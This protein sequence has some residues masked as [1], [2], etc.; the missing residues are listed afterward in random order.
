M[1][2]NR[3]SCASGGLSNISTG[4]ESVCIDTYRVLDSC[5]DKDCYEN[6]RVYLTDFGQEILN[7]TTNIRTKRADILRT[8][9]NVS[10]VQFNRGFYQI[11]IRYYVRIVFEACVGGSGRAQEFEGIAVVEKKVVLYGSEGCVNIYRSG[12]NDDFCACDNGE[13]ANY[14]N[15]MPVATVE[16][17]DPVVL[18]MKIVEPHCHG[19]TPSCPVPFDSIPESIGSMIGGCLVC[20]GDLHLYVSLGFFSIVRIERP[21]Q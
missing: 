18:G 7:H 9:I 12:V 8:C 1:A 4:K 11:E 17:A 2:E 10:P 5:R 13:G 19:F 6:T 21:A 20:G 3:C 14:S 15:N 16:V